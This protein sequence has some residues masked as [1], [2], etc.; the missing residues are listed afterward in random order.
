M[1]LEK[2]SVFAVDDMIRANRLLNILHLLKMENKHAY[3]QCRFIFTAPTIDSDKLHYP[4]NEVN[5]YL[6]SKPLIPPLF[7]LELHIMCIENFKDLLYFNIEFSKEYNHFLNVSNAMK[8]VY[9]QKTK[10][11]NMKI[12]FSNNAHQNLISGPRISSFHSLAGYLVY[13]EKGIVISDS[14]VYEYL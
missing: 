12:L 13:N 9:Y 2:S 10:L 14:K 7:P 1:S 3:E 11:N 6:H 4:E 8:L 5:S